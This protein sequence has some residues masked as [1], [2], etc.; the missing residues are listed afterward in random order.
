MGLQL[1]HAGDDRSTRAGACEAQA[2]APSGLCWPDMTFD[3]DEVV[4]MAMPAYC[5]TPGG[6]LWEFEDGSFWVTTPGGRRAP[7]RVDDVWDAPR[8]GWSHPAGCECPAC[9]VARF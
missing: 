4:A 3:R 8:D 6:E 5:W 2:P 7:R 9:C 1:D